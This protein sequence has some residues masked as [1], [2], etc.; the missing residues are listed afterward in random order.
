[1]TELDGNKLTPYPKPR[2]RNR[3]RKKEEA[4]K[5]LSRR[6]RCPICGQ[7]YSSDVGLTRCK[8]CNMP[9]VKD[10][11]DWDPLVV[12]DRIAGGPVRTVP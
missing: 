4:I 10:D 2:N 5:P 3:N 1:M 11:P 9:Y 6:V 12:A 7:L 8:Q